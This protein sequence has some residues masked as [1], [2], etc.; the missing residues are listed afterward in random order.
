MMMPHLAIYTDDP[1]KGGVAQ[2]NHTL[3]LALAR[4]GWRVSLVQTR[5]T[6]PHVAEREAAGIRH[7]WIDY[8]TQRDFART[9]VD[10]SHGEAAFT[11]LSPDLVLFSDC[12]PVSNIAAKH[13]AIQ[14]RLPFVTVVNFAA[15]YL[16]DRFKSC[17]PVTAAQYAAASEV[18]AVST[19]N[20]QL[21][22]TRFGLNA[23]K[24]RVIFYGIPDSFFADPVPADRARMRSELGLAANAFVSL[25][26]A[27][28]AE[29]KLHVLQVQAMALLARSGGPMP[30]CV[31]IGEGELRPQLEQMVAGLGIAKQFRLVGKQSPVWP[32]LDMADVFT[33][34]SS[35]E[36]MPIAIMEAMARGLPVAATA[37]SGIP[38]ELGGEGALLPSPDRDPSATARQ[39][40][41][42]WRKWMADPKG[43]I[44]AGIR[45]RRRAAE[46]FRESD[47]VARTAAVLAHALPRPAA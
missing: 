10:A 31:W 9:I 22:R 34:T 4:R 27:R 37:V 35:S 38:E 17:L 47:M 14:R 24:G 20:L 30:V 6:S 26:A 12:C 25:T 33:L 5:S 19:E 3:A 29:V 8:D 44:D 42:V 13:T 21:L 28:L 40:A 23:R 11:H 45:C 16:A 43:R 46:Q 39:L 41:A 7:W 1:D 36:G 32:W 18:I 15:A 2:Y